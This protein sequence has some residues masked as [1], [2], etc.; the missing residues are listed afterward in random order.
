[1]KTRVP[2]L[3]AK[4]N[5]NVFTYTLVSEVDARFALKMKK[6]GRENMQ[7]IIFIPSAML[8]PRLLVCS[9]EKTE[10]LQGEYREKSETVSNIYQ[11]YAADTNFHR[12]KNIQTLC[13]YNTD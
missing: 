10:K 7:E 3:P 4:Q 9:R 1:M 12:V 6:Q 8:D 2:R 11:I 5:A 13:S